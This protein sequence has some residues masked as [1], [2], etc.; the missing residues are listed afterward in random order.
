MKTPALIAALVLACATL[1]AAAQHQHGAAAT[2]ATA[3][4]DGEVRRVDAMKGTILLKHGEMK[5][6][7]MGPMTMGFKLKDPK[8]ALGLKEG[9]KVRFT[10]MAQGNELIVT[11]IK[12]VQ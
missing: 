5:G 4:T 8:M 7:G 9:D 11:E 1:P 2:A 12:K 10:A 3:T 6:L